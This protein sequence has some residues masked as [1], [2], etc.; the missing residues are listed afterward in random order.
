MCGWALG[1]AIIRR[2]GEWGLGKTGG[3]AT[4]KIYAFHIKFRNQSGPVIRIRF[5]GK[6]YANIK[7]CT[8]VVPLFAP[9]SWGTKGKIGILVQLHYIKLKRLIFKNCI[10][11]LLSYRGFFFPP[12]PAHVV[13]AAE[14]QTKHFRKAFEGHRTFWPI[15]SGSKWERWNCGGK[16]PSE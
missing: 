8:N 9:L 16:F 4:N 10:E 14:K 1:E 3:T 6:F 11:K 15:R 12:P 7:I 5:I 2:V 13:H